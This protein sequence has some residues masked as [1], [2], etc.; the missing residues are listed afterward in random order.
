MK[1]YISGS[2]EPE[3]RKQAVEALVKNG[4]EVIDS[5]DVESQTWILSKRGKA[6]VRMSLIPHCE[7][8]FMMDGWQDC[9]IAR[10][11]FDKAVEEKLIICF[12][13]KKDTVKRRTIKA[14]FI[15]PK[16]SFGEYVVLKRK[17]GVQ[18]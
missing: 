6:A 7:A 10:K 13:G 16:F 8:I 15:P 14:H 4:H 5:K 1:I 17:K 3:K 18:Q 9:E 12:E 11:E 2:E